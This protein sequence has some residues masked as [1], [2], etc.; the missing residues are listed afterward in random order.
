[1]DWTNRLLGWNREFTQPSGSRS[2]WGG[3]SVTDQT[4]F[5]GFLR[6]FHVHVGILQILLLSG[7]K[8]FNFL[9]NK[10][11]FLLNETFK[12]ALT[13]GEGCK[14]S[15]LPHLLLLHI[16]QTKNTLCSP[17]CLFPVTSHGWIDTHIQ[18]E[19][20][21][22]RQKKCFK[23]FLKGTFIQKLNNRQLKADFL[24]SYIRKKFSLHW[25]NLEQIFN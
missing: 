12:Q 6:I 20:K 7:K 13:C 3:T 1:M 19:E 22:W 18:Y 2:G 4:S 21:I 15:E 17:L 25:S 8:E 9:K 10:S 11:K 14:V 24:F 16:Y 5:T 23:N